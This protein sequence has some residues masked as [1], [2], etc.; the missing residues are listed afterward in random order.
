MIQVNN[1]IRISIIV[2]I[3]NKKNSLERCINSILNQTYKNIEI[4]LVNDG[5]T[6]GSYTLCNDYLQKDKR[7]KVIHK[8]NEGV[9]SARNIGINNSNGEYIQFV[10]CDDYIDK[11]MCESLIE[12][13]I[14]HNADIIFCGYKV[15]KNNM[16][17][18][19]EG[20]DRCICTVKEIEEEFSELYKRCFFNAPWNKLFKKSIIKSEFN[21]DLS[22]GED[23]I[24]NLE[25]IKQS[26]KIVFLKECY[27]NYIKD[28]DNSLTS[29]YR[30]D[31]Y[32]IAKNLYT[33][34]NNFCDYYNIDYSYR[35]GLDYIF[36]QDV[37]G[38]IKNVIGDFNKGKKEK[39]E[40][41]LKCISDINV[42][43]AMKS[44]KSDKHLKNILRI[45]VKYNMSTCIYIIY[46]LKESRKSK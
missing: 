2:P 45:L 24:F 1:K 5:S 35:Y 36:I 25:S 32:N 41:I 4:I 3:Y 13:A 12:A 11:N 23:L 8:K 15:I 40:T 22:L 34:V 27:Y 44:Y 10:D 7:I 31:S 16:K 6:D 17:S 20:I 28:E 42:K 43:S 39:K 14:K 46:Y 30:E 29:K 18:Y 21:Q 38:Y 33:E 9:S 37:F 26:K 19:E